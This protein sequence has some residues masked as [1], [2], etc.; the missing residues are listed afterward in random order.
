MDNI[1]FD[2]KKG[3]I[4][5]LG[6]NGAGKSTT[7]R[8]LSTLAHPTSGTATIGGYDIVKNDTEV[9]KLIGIVSEK[10]IMYNRLTARENLW[11]FGS[12]FDI[13]KDE[14]TKRMDELV[15]TGATHQMEELAGRHF[16]N[17]HAPKNE[18][19]SGLAQFA[20]GAVFG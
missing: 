18:R 11:F 5:G 17:W 12:L 7:L 16:F 6:P 19:D 4:F 10:M 1:S 15:G 3:E 8:M 9:R 2:V 13:P 14:L 20:S